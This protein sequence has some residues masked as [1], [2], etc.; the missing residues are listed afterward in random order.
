MLPDATDYFYLF[1]LCQNMSPAAI[2]HLLASITFLIFATVF[3]VKEKSRYSTF[4]YAMLGYFALTVAIIYQ[5]KAPAYFNLLCWQSIIVISTAIWFRS[6]FIILA[7]F[8]IYI[9]IFIAYLVMEGKISGI[10]LSF[11]IVALLSARILNW[12]KDRLE[13]KTEQMRNA[14]LLTALVIIPYALFHAMPSG[15]ISVSWIIVAIIYY[16]LS[17]VL[18][19]KKYRWMALST[20]GLTVGYVFIIGVTNEDPVYKIVSFLALGFVMLIISIIYSKKKKSQAK[21]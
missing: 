18:K 17:V 15:F 10:S 4:I 11:G 16:V 20:L 6:K 21:A 2:Y 8:I 12:K 19:S 13:L 1:H 3:W 14:Y 5:V 9:L 7:N